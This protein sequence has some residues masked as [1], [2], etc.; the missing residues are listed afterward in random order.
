MTVTIN[1]QGM[2]KSGYISAGNVS[3][4]KAARQ[5]EF[6][7]ILA[8]QTSALPMAPQLP[9]YPIRPGLDR[10]LQISTEKAPSGWNGHAESW[11]PLRGFQL[12]STKTISFCGGKVISQTVWVLGLHLLPSLSHRQWE[13]EHLNFK[14]IFFLPSILV[15]HCHCLPVGW[16]QWPTAVVERDAGLAMGPSPLPSHRGQR[17]A[18]KN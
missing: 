17:K 13:S 6:L 12:P 8:F 7:N 2:C 16:L 18:F 11:L 9:C 15:C 1:A 5:E 10:F 4:H 3:L 14:W